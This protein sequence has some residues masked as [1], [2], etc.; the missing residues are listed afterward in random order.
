VR[1]RAAPAF[2]ALLAAIA[3][4]TAAAQDLSLMFTPAEAWRRLPAQRKTAM[5]ADFMRVF[6]V[7]QTMPAEALVGCLDK[8]P[9]GEPYERAIGCVKQ[10]SANP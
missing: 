9:D 1:R 2:V 5:A 4:G 10:L 3:A 8:A 6:C 7:Q